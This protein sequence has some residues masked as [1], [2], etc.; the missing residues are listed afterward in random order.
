MF[1]TLFSISDISNSSNYILKLKEELS[2][3]GKYYEFKKEMKELKENIP[4]NKIRI[5]SSHTDIE[6]YLLLLFLCNEYKNEEINL[7]VTYS[8]EY[9]SFISPACLN[10]HELEK[11]SKLEH[12]LSKEEITNYSKIWQEL[13]N[14]N[15][16]LRVIEKGKILSVNFDYFDNLILDTLKDLGTITIASL[17]GTLLSKTI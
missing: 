5:W 14:I 7:Y 13:V 8:E 1:N 17:I 6:P 10:E 9:K 16:P 12:K 4:K 3:F 11:L 2:P 15:S